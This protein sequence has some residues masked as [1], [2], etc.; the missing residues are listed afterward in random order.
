[1]R[2]GLH[3]LGIGVG[4]QRAV[5]DAVAR[6]AEDGGFSTLWAGEH[7][8]MV[9]RPSSRYPYA[10][11]GQIAVPPDADWLDPLVCLSFVAA[12]THTIT[13]ATGIVLLAEH[14][15]LLVAKQAASLDVLSG[16]RLMLGVGIGWSADEFAALGVPFSGRAQRT[17]EHVE[18]MRTLWREDLASFDGCFVRFDAVRVYPKPARNRRVPVI[19]G[20]NSDAALARV[21]AHGDGWYGFNLSGV[22]GVREHITRLREHCKRAGRDLSELYIAVAVE[23]CHPAQLPEL[24]ELGVDEL[25][26]V[27]APP[28]DSAAAAS[29]VGDLADRW[30]R[31]SS[32]H[33]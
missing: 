26:V 5:I 20:G 2:L 23:G 17:V 25:V 29:W 4:A 33:R 7:V 27:D 22:A 3:A 18:V 10:P 8:V 19:F 32:G 14:N 30:V 1:M 16:G 6:A 21:A 31:P 24:A 11:D 9:D 15:P 13:V 28:A 12:A